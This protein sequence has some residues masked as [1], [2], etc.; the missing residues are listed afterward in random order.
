[1]LLGLPLAQ[2]VYIIELGQYTRMVLPVSLS[3]SMGFFWKVGRFK[4]FKKR[5]TYPCCTDIKSVFIW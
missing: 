3:I 2:G 5:L 4:R 1:M